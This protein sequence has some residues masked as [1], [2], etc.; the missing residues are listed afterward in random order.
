MRPHVVVIGSSNTDLV[1][2]TAKLPRPGETVAGREF[3]IHAGGKGA[4]QAVAA[5][6]AGAKVTLVASIGRDRFGDAAVSGLEREKIDTQWI[7]RSSARPSG[8]ALILTDRQ[9]ENMISVA[10]GSNEDLEA[11]HVG[12]A[13]PA[14]REAGCVV[15]QLEVPM[16][17]IHEAARLASGFGVPMLLNPAPATRLTP[18]LLAALSLLTPNKGELAALTGLSVRHRSDIP[19]AACRLRQQGVS[20][21]LVTCGVDGVCWCSDQGHRWFDAPRVKAVDTVGAG[22]CFSGV[23]AAALARGEAMVDA[24]TFAVTAAAICVTRNGAQPSMP[25]RKEILARLARGPGIRR[26]FARPRSRSGGSPNAR[27]S[28]GRDNC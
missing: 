16:A 2:R 6:R 11:R 15:T 14:I 21:I 26:V 25:R 12:A 1:V 19:V 24:I 22:D 17:A 4:N 8:V 23:L 7:V 10:S 5:A 13:I 9:G 27:T 20:H 18:D 28:T 3:A